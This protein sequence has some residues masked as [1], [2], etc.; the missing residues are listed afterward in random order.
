MA[1]VEFHTGFDGCG[2]TNDLLSFF[3][4]NQYHASL[5]ITNGYDNSKCLRLSRSYYDAGF[6]YKNVSPAKTKDCAFHFKFTEYSSGSEYF[7]FVGPG[8]KIRFSGSSTG[9]DVY[10]GSTKLCDSGGIAPP[11]SPMITHVEIKVFSDASIGTVQL[12]LNGSIVIDQSGLNT[13]GQDI[14]SIKFF[15]N[16][17]Y[18]S[19]YLYIDDLAIADDWIGHSTVEKKSPISDSS[20]AF[21]PSTGTDNYAMIDDS[22]HDGDATY[23]ETVVTGQD[24]YGY[25]T[26]DAGKEIVAVSLVTVARKTGAGKYPVYLQSATKQDAV[27]YLKSQRALGV[28]YPCVQGSGFYDEYPT[29]PDGSAW[30]PAIWNAMQLGFKATL[31]SP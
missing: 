19:R 29:S 26:V 24:L 21:T 12:W 13:G 1:T 23:V 11:L 8:I 10:R 25:E 4:G 5:D 2:S 28:Q 31:T 3:D 15:N 17:G 16:D 14:S 30:T 9:I 20:I 6:I 22:G 7:E 18:G 27:E